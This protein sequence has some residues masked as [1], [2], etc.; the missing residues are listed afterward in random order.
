MIRQ[1][2]GYGMYL[3]LLHQFLHIAFWAGNMTYRMPQTKLLFNYAIDHKEENS[4]SLFSGFTNPSSVHLANNDENE[5]LLS[6]ILL[7]FL[8]TIQHSVMARL[9]FQSFIKT[10]FPEWC[11]RCIF[12]A[13]SSLSFRFIY[14]YWQPISSPAWHLYG[15]VAL[16]A[17]I[18]Y[19]VGLFWVVLS[20]YTSAVYDFFNLRKSFTSETS[21]QV[22][23]I[24]PFVYK[25][26]RMPL[27][28]GM[29]LCFWATSEMTQGRLL[30]AML[31]TIY[32][33]MAGK[34][35][36]RDLRSQL[37]SAYAYYANTV[38]MLIPFVSMKLV[39]RPPKEQGTNDSSRTSKRRVN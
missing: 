30:F 18:L 14:W 36:E 24:I 12:L 2:L 22:P 27:F 28:S 4:F 6:D 19:F 3:V 11:E 13:M 39:Y 8:F 26:T 7:V 17:D 20:I 33:L 5:A 25:F 31:F 29:L 37:G 21:P 15:V 35:Q 10:H 23:Q 9:G 32:T 16:I 1:V 34:W 38:P